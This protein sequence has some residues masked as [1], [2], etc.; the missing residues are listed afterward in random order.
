MTSG[1]AAPTKTDPPHTGD[2]AG[3]AIMEQAGMEHVG[4]QR[5]GMAYAERDTGAL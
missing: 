5:A 2:S 3:Q 1:R 4:K